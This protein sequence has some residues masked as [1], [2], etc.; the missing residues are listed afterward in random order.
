MLPTK[1]KGILES[2]AFQDAKTAEDHRVGHSIRAAHV[3]TAL[4]PRLILDHQ[5]SQ[6][7]LLKGAR[8]VIHIDGIAIARIRVGQ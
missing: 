5:P 4:R 6:P 8:R 1:G 2:G 3:S 7:G